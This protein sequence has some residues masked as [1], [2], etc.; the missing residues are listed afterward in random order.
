[1]STPEI[2]EALKDTD[3]WFTVLKSLAQFDEM[4]LRGVTSGILSP[5]LPE[6]CVLSIYLRTAGNVSS[7]L[8]LKSP[9]HFQA[10]GM[11]ARSVFEQAVDIGI[12][13]MVQGAPIKMRVFLDIEKLRA[14]RSAVAFAKKNPL[15]LQHSVQTQENYIV[16]NEARIVGLAA[17]TWPGL[18]FTD[19]TH[20]SGI[21]LPARVRMLPVEMLELYDCYYRQLSWSVHS[22]LEG[23][24]GLQ[25]VAFPRMC[26]MA[27]NLAARNYEKVL[28]HVIRSL[29]LN[30][31]DPLIENKMKLARFLPFTED[32]QQEA[33]LRRDLGR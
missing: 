24:Y 20:W 2:D 9:K 29:K 16:N 11:L 6:E 8:E 14:C 13:D 1:M 15:A 3:L 21:R 32:A 33:A 17:T 4:E 23:S 7:L 5:T 19:I 18:K 28:T 30:K 10:I 26:G 27:F 31:A 25:P 22:G 12:F